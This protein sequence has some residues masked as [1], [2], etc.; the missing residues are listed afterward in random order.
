MS[1]GEGST[2][3]PAA[4]LNRMTDAFFALDEEWNFT[5]VNDR[6]R[7]FLEAAMDSNASETTFEGRTFWETIPAAVDTEFGAAYREAMET[8]ETVELE[9][10]YD[11]LDTW[12][13]LRAYPSE[14]GLSV[15]F[16]DV[17]ERHATHEKL[18]DRERTLQQIYEITA[19]TD[20]GFE[21]QV[22]RLLEIGCEQLGTS[23]GTLSRIEGQEYVFEIVEAPAGTIEAGETV[24]LSVTNCERVATEE[25]AL[26]LGNIERD[27]PELAERAGNQDLGIACYVGAPIVV[28]EEVYGTFCFYHERARDEPFENWQ[29]T[30]VDLLS[31]WVSYELTHQRI[32]RQLRDQNEQLEQFASIVSHDLRNPLNVMGGSLTIAA[33]SGDSAAF[34]RCRNAIERMET[35]IDDLLTLAKAGDRITTLETVPL[36]ELAAKSWETVEAQG[37][38]LAIETGE[39]IRADPGRLD[40]LLSNLFR[41]AVDHAGEDL[42]VTLGSLPDGFYVADDGAGIP[43]DE[44]D[45]VLDAGYSSSET[46]TGFGLNIV[47]EIADAHDWDLEITASEAGGARFEF[48]G[49]ECVTRS[50]PEREP[51]GAPHQIAIHARRVRPRYLYRHVPVCRRVGRVRTGRG[52]RQGGPGRQRGS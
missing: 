52:R 45:R 1:D 36:A 28:E 4:I 39:S 7:P 35:L 40:Q 32:H 48:S 9:A 2:E 24:P 17:T 38:T 5:Y 25:E 30:L 34:E 46:G 3:S 10:Y 12:F 31:Q 16:R 6:A 47:A 23:Y 21:E 8:Q 14:S 37:V 15:Y 27:A 33:E 20:L 49:V 42:T 51:Q 41:N 50:V 22:S 43:P 19:D 44:R 26:V 11:P 13:E 29:I 18:A